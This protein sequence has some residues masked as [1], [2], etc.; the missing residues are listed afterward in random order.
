MSGDKSV[1]C[2]RQDVL[3]DLP[4]MFTS[5]GL[6]Q[7]PVPRLSLLQIH[8]SPAMVMPVMGW[9]TI[10]TWHVTDPWDMALA[11]ALVEAQGVRGFRKPAAQESVTRG[12]QLQLCPV[13]YVPPGLPPPSPHL[14]YLC[15]PCQAQGRDSNRGPARGGTP[16]GELRI[17]TFPGAMPQ[18]EQRRRQ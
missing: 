14:L 12:K 15:T 17:W 4:V 18:C 2:L 10:V 13:F 5:G 1:K 8:P 7:P 6:S 3:V 11:G 16:A 9:K